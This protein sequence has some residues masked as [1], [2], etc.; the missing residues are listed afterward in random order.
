MNH[1]ALENRLQ[2]EIDALVRKNKDVFSAVLGVAKMDG[3]F[4]LFCDP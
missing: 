3:D 2:S 4:R 1:R